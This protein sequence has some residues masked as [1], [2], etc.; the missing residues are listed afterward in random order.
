MSFDILHAKNKK[1][2]SILSVLT[3]IMAGTVVMLHSDESDAS[4]DGTQSNPYTVYEDMI[5]AL[6]EYPT[7]IYFNQGAEAWFELPSTWVNN[8]LLDFDI[9]VK[10]ITFDGYEFVGGNMNS[11]GYI[12]VINNSTEDVVADYWF[13]V[14][15]S[16]LPDTTQTATIT[17]PAGKTWTWTPETSTGAT[18]TVAGSN[19]AMPTSGYANSS[20]Y[21]SV[22]NGKVTV[23]IPS[24]Y[25]GD[26]YYVSIRATSTNPTQNAYTNITFNTSPISFTYSANTVHAKVGTAISN[27][28]PTLTN[29][30]ASAYSINETLPSGLT[31][32]T[33][34]GV[35]S[36]T[37]T[38]YKAQTD[39]VITVTTATVPSYT[40]SYTVSIGAFTN[41]S[42]SS[43]YSYGITNN[44]D[45]KIGGVSMPT[46]TTLDK[47]TVTVDKDG[48]NLS[49]SSGKY[50]GLTVDTTTGAITGKCTSAGK[51]VF[52]EK[53]TA[54]AN[55]GG[56]VKTRIVAITVENQATMSGNATFEK[57]QGTSATSTVSTNLSNKTF[58]IASV[59]KDGTSVNASNQG[60]TINASTGAITSATST[61]LGTYVITVKVISTKS[62]SVIGATSNSGTTPANNTTTKT[63]TLTVYPVMT[64]SATS[65]NFYEAVGGAY[66]S[67]KLT[68]STSANFTSSNTD[69][70]TVDSNGNLKV[71]NNLVAGTYT[72][73]VTATDKNHST[74]SAS[75]NINVTVKV[76]LYFTNS[77]YAGTVS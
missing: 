71:G 19:S 50:K 3:V 58:S 75:I 10:G 56:S 38:T 22:S 17:L 30:T 72:V 34:T 36:G 33:S 67:N 73:T 23:A 63:V 52:T 18:V 64:V 25:T 42:A 51:Y 77:P 4:G 53:F 5:T 14:V 31:F 27:L 1:L 69:V 20:G 37:P 26:H 7:I 47:M 41:I 57:K 15:Q 39:Y 43:Y 66:D 45:F 48:S 49:A 74:N 6:P 8:N 12:R 59:T 68:V 32:N 65:N 24:N 9:T 61:G 13:K 28:T 29:A 16:S 40:F 62:Y 46:G 2:I 70:L 44:T 55:T 21:A 76:Q 35:I 54:T 60:I 11:D